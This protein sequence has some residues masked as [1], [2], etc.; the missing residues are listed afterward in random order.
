M[1]TARVPNSW[2]DLQEVVAN[3]LLECGFSVELE[4]V[5]D[6]GRGKAE[7]DVYAEETIGGRLNKIICECKHWK[8]AVPQQVVHAFRTIT[9]EVGA[10]TGYIIASSGFQAGAYQAVERTNVRLVTWEEFQAEFEKVWLDAYFAPT[11]TSELDP[12]M[13][14]T[15]PFV[16]PW[17]DE[18]S[19]TDRTKFVELVNQH[20]PLGVLAMR[21]SI[22]HQ[23]LNPGDFPELPLGNGRLVSDIPGLPD[24][25]L[26]AAGYADLLDILL[27]RGHA[28]IKEFLEYRERATGDQQS[29]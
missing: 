22:Y 7:I 2:Q 27:G 16:P 13:S 15:E 17:F 23:K 29:R 1:I 14:Y 5:L 3:I 4:Y 11:I 9:A 18:L 10:N 24:D 20:V 19:E 21:L 25:V 12:L 28:A 8:S 26:A 6:L